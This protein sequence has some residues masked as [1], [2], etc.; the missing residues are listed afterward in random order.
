LADGGDEKFEVERL[1]EKCM[2]AS[3]LCFGN[4]LF[5]FGC[6]NSKKYDMS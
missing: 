6:G 1:G 5:G 4:D 3:G 2:E